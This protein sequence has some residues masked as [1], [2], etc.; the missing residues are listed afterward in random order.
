MGKPTLRASWIAGTNLLVFTSGEEVDAQELV[1]LWGEKFPSVLPKD[2]KIDQTRW[3]REEMELL[4]ERMNAA[5]ADT[6]P[7]PIDPFSRHIERLQKRIYVPWLTEPVW[8]DRSKRQGL[9]EELTAWWQTNRAKTYWSGKH[10]ALIVKGQTPEELEAARLKQQKEK[11]DAFLS[12]KLTASEIDVAT[13]KLTANFEREHEEDAKGLAR[14]YNK[15]TPGARVSWTKTG[16]GRWVLLYPIGG[17]GPLGSKTFTG[18]EVQETNDRDYP[19]R[20]VFQLEWMEP[21]RKK[22]IFDQ[23]VYRYHRLSDRWLLGK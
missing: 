2:F 22:P 5:L 7:K 14:A 10:Q 20:A 9:F 8:L 15:Y 13:R 1:E 3:G 21:Q 17:S 23:D 16:E 18:P 11:L 12:K 6:T 19:L 4:L